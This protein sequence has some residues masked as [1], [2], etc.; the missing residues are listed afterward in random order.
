VVTACFK[1]RRPALFGGK[2]DGMVEI[3]YDLQN[4]P[5][6]MKQLALVTVFTWFALFSMFI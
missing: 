5:G 4:M 2:V 6:A 1:L 3:I